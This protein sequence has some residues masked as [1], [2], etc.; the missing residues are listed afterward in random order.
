MNNMKLDLD[1]KK[2]LPI[3]R[4]LQPYIFG[5]ILIGVF[6]YTALIV[7]TALNVKADVTEPVAADP[8]AK[9]SFDK[10]TIEAVKKLDVVQ[11]NVPIGDLGK[12]DPFK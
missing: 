10:P 3:L 12:S 6:G 11:G 2:L 8:A 9:I 5:M 4:Q 7:N 1:Y